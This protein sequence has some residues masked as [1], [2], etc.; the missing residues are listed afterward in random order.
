MNTTELRKP[1]MQTLAV[2][3]SVIFLIALASGSETTSFLGLVSAIVT[4]IFSLIWY[5]IV[6][7]FAIAFSIACLFAVFLGGVALYSMEDSKKIY[8]QLRYHLARVWAEFRKCEAPAELPKEET[9]VAV[10][11]EEP[12]EVVK[13]EET[14]PV[15]SDDSIAIKALEEKLASQQTKEQELQNTI[16]SL[17][18]QLETKAEAALG[19]Q[20]SG[21]ASAQ[22]ET[23]NTL[24]STATR[25]DS[26]DTVIKDQANT[27]AQISTT[28]TDLQKKVEAAY[29]SDLSG[30]IDEMS[31]KLDAISTADLEKQVSELQKK[32]EK[33]ADDKLAGKVEALEKKLE[34]A[35]SEIL[36]LQ[37]LM[38][39]PAE[40][41]AAP[42]KKKK[43]VKPEVEHRIFSYLDDPKDRELFAVKV[44]E[45]VNKD[46]TYA[47]IDDFLTASLTKE[48]DKIIKD[49]P[50]LTKDYVRHTKKQ[51]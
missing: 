13:E 10:Q 8:G 19:D 24:T 34:D 29:T 32:V 27:T 3:A 46:M 7:P 22:E 40:E 1:L 5:I 42:K 15:E 12:E 6:L 17:S 51:S 2:V 37:S 4:G 43:E 30:K 45:A 26:L 16:N 36:Q 20:V 50:S 21:L 9:T 35:N 33:A 31:T 49:H 47:E 25:V 44:Q 41:A 48:A 28:L 23:S 39:A 38:T 11:A 14:T 18:Q